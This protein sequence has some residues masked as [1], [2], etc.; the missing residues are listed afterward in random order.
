MHAC[1]A[2]YSLVDA[3]QLERPRF[4]GDLP[5]V[6][7]MKEVHP[8]AF[9]LRGSR[10]DSHLHVDRIV[11]IHGQADGNF[12]TTWDLDGLGRSSVANI[13]LVTSGLAG[14]SLEFHRAR[15]RRVCG[16]WPVFQTRVWGIGG[17]PGPLNC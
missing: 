14:S 17:H 12:V 13:G 16:G 3:G 15:T 9:H 8:F 4:P 6:I 10:A 1:E 11:R 7:N 5:L 2:H